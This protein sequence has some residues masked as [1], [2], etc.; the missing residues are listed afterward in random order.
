MANH[1]VFIMNPRKKSVFALLLIALVI[2]CA[3]AAFFI[4]KM[5]SDV[6]FYPFPF[7]PWEMMELLEMV[8]SFGLLMGAGTSLLL[9]IFSARRIDRLSDQIGALSGKFQEYIERQFQE[10]NLTPTERSV[11]LLVI[12]GFSN[13]EIAQLRGTKESTI[14]SQLT[15]IY[16]KTG[17]SS[18]QQLTTY[19]IEDLISTLEACPEKALE[20]ASEDAGRKQVQG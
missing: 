5:L 14:K 6:L 11:A 7:V 15:S 12:K 1:A 13:A 16:F 19:F 9:M 17:L 18:R 10:W 20:R 4:L 8:A 2:Q 3:G